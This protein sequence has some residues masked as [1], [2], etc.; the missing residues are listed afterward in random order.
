ML[1]AWI[2]SSRTVFDSDW[3]GFKAKWAVLLRKLVILRLNIVRSEFWAVVLG[4]E[5]STK[6]SINHYVYEIYIS[7]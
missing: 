3:V 7:K 5:P 4:V 2:V 1:V 6:A